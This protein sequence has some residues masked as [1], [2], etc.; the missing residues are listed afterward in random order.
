MSHIS[1]RN[2]NP[3]EEPHANLEWVGRT[4]EVLVDK[5]LVTSREMVGRLY[6]STTGRVSVSDSPFILGR[7]A[8]EL[9]LWLAYRV[10][11]YL[12]WDRVKE[13]SLAPG[14]SHTESLEW[15]VGIERSVAETL[16]HQEILT[17]GLATSLISLSG[18][19][20][21]EQDKEIRISASSK[22]VLSTTDSWSNSNSHVQE[23]SIWQRVDILEFVPSISP[24]A[25]R[26]QLEGAIALLALA[27]GGSD[28]WRTYR[29]EI[30]AEAVRT[31]SR[32][33]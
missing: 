33:V 5:I 12:R 17:Y 19:D 26:E 30:L 16:K 18:K 20:E 11:H 14:Q 31:K 7:K 6:N 1:S 22:A 25:H 2:V 24:L 28:K 13:V 21:K 29:I 8:E 27:P 4:K 32:Y 3:P 9:P 23:I 15:T 10:L